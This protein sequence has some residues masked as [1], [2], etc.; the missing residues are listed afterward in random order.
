MTSYL[1]LVLI[2]AA[3]LLYLVFG[4]SFAEIHTQVSF[5]DFPIFISEWLMGF[6]VL[7][8]IANLFIEPVRWRGWRVG[9]VVY[10]FWVMFKAAEGYITGGGYALRNAALFYYPIFAVFVAHFLRGIKFGQG[11]RILFCVILLSLVGFVPVRINAQYVFCIAG[12]F[13]AAGLTRRWLRWTFL[14]FF[15]CIF[16]VRFAL[17]SGGRGCL[18]GALASIL[19]LVWYSTQV[20]RVVFWKQA[21]WI[22]IL[23]GALCV[24]LWRWGDHNALISLVNPWKTFEMYHLTVERVKQGEVNFI[25]LGLKAQIYHKDTQDRLLSE[26]APQQE[27]PAASGPSEGVGSSENVGVNSLQQDDSTI[28]AQTASVSPSPQAEQ[29][30]ASGPSQ[31]VDSPENVG[32]NSLQQD[33]STI[34]AQTVSVSLSPQAEQPSASGPSQGVDSPEIVGV[35]SLQ[36]DDSTIPAQS[37]SVSP[38]PQTESSASAQAKGVDSAQNRDQGYRDL[39]SAYA[40]GVFRLLIWQDMLQEII[41]A[42]PLFGFSFGWPQRSASLEIMGWGLDEWLRDGWIT[43]HNSFLHY[44]YRG[45][46]VGLGIIVWI[47]WLIIIMTGHFLRVR[48]WQGG[49]LVSSLVF[50]II[51]AQF[52]VILELPYNAIPFWSLFGLTVAYYRQLRKSY[53]E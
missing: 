3:V 33:D 45:G 48:S 6:C 49:L 39:S 2:A 34:P 42:R 7:V 44:I 20:M 14:G 26:N 51:Q 9:I 53:V 35:N 28:P 13:V 27:E 31:G 47:L 19:F 32:V 46:V 16:L 36:Q 10:F 52:G 43:P 40:N 1:C 22:S 8:L 38:S 12:L 23:G 29:P 30:S 21:L 50:W 41:N 5:L 37:A 25:P 4:S 18:I 15:L 11:V 17:M 24:S